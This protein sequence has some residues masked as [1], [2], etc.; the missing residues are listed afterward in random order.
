MVRSPIMRAALRSFVAALSLT[1]AAPSAWAQPLQSPSLQESLDAAN[2]AMG[3]QAQQDQLARQAVLQQN[4]LTVLEAQIRTEQAI[5]DIQ[6]HSRTPQ[7][8]P[9]PSGASPNLDTSQLASSP[10]ARLAESNARVKAAAA[11]HH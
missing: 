2:R 11:H 3:L 7:I 6:A 4:Q 10:D 8:P 9:P 5:A 1:S